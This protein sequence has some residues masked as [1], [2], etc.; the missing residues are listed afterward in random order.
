ME[1]KAIGNI[2]CMNVCLFV[3]CL[4]CDRLLIH[5]HASIQ[6]PRHPSLCTLSVSASGASL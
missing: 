4:F 3:H 6:W 5:L 2:Y 1:G